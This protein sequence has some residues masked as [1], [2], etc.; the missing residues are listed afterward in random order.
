MKNI[1]IIGLLFFIGLAGCDTDMNTKIDLSGEWQFQTDPDDRGVDEKWYENELPE[2][3][4]LP[5]SMVENG[6]G[7]DIPLETQWTGGIK[8]PDWYKDPNYA[9]YVD[10]DNVRF[11]FWLQPEKKYTGAAWYRKKFTV[12]S[13]WQE[14]T[15]RLTLERPHWESTVWVNGERAGM[16]NSLAV[17]HVFDVSPFLK[18]GENVLT[19]RI[20][21]RTK[22]IDVGENSHSISDHTQSNWNGIVGDI[23]LSAAGKITF[24]NVEIFPDI[25]SKAVEIRAT[26]NNSL[27]EAQ[28]VTFT[29]DAQL[30]K[31]GA[32]TEGKS[33]EFQ[34]S[35]G[36]NRIE[37]DYPLGEDAL[38]WDEFNPNV[39]ELL[40][41]LKSENETDNHAADFGLREFTVDGTHLAINGR[42]V[43][44]RGTLECAIFPLTGYPPTETEYWEKIY[45]A[46][47]AH[48]LNHLRFH[49]W[50]PPEA[51]FDAAD[52]M[53][54]F[55]QVECSSWANQS[56]QLGSG[57][58]IDQY[59]WDESKRIVKAYGNHPSFVMM[60][61][62]N[63]PGGPKSNDFLT[64]FVTYWKEK[65]N[66]R[67][68]TSAAGWPVLEVNQF[69][70][71][72]EPRIQGWGEQLNS[73]INAEPPRTDYDWSEKVPGDGIPVMSHEIGQWCVYPNFK[74]ME[75]Y[76][77]VLKPKNFEIFRESLEAHH[78]G[79][80]ADSFLL[81]SG[82]L[83]ALCYKADIEAALRTPGF[84]GFQLL[85]LHDFPGQG[86]ALVGVLDPF[87]E[88]KGYISP[89]E[90]RSFCNTTVPL[91]RLKKRIF[92]EG[93]TM[94]AKIEVAHFGETPLQAVNP[95]WKL[96]QNGNTIAEGTWEQRDIPIGNAIQ[97]GQVVHQ[98]Q[99][100]N[101]PRKL[102]LAVRVE[103][104]ENSWDIW[105]YPENQDTE[106]DEI[107]VVENLNNTTLNFLKNGG[108]VLLSLGRGKV[109]PEMGGD[110][111][112]GF[113]SIFWN[114]AWTDNQKPH[115]LGILCNPEHPTLEQFPTEYHSNWQW[116][117]AVSHADAIQIDSLPV[118]LK[119][120]VRI[121][122]DWVTNRSLALLFEAKV[123]KGSILVS[124]TDLVNNLFSRPE[125][126][127]L[128]TSL[129]SYMESNRFNPAHQLNAD[130]LRKIVK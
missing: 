77:G 74:E 7:D 86:T 16:Q 58:P 76:T 96:V 116:W 50:C 112:V 43:F 32:T 2:T 28:T 72:P 97:L 17:P 13:G 1:W 56:T 59:I 107:R 109:S 128:K 21:N 4:Q 42:P 102:T 15:V 22:D 33:W 129:L 78:L 48:G 126:R 3:V 124:G 104:F 105:V 63:E 18:E 89:E 123:G 122:D 69:H 118:E 10:P 19:V 115:T 36:E 27:G 119:P 66:R 14:K 25:T 55:L 93:E 8:N 92:T 79:H 31:T 88:E 85:D 121:I 49:S 108:K 12:P 34:I 35:P 41:T 9:P 20:D 11:P 99:N 29:A 62:G 90:Y 117:D 64:E 83:Q 39:Y 37:M 91:A 38:L 127:Q 6:K 106:T 5:G 120:I 94:T 73:V 30:K 52:E 84:A 113:S 46:V 100:K 40:L 45:T 110:V 101:E 23:S 26:V 54:V 65:D 68:Y 71:I 80:L 82:K 98:F 60:A 61:Y 47:Q 103:A 53:G 67:V 125:A 24:E 70:D 87:W 114:T 81:A 111:G 51:A 130:D 44:L 75:K 57:L 95:A